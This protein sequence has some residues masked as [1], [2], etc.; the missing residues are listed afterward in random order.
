MP[1]G[2]SKSL[3]RSIF[4]FDLILLLFSEYGHIGRHIPESRVVAAR[5]LSGELT[6]VA[7]GA[8]RRRRRVQQSKLRIVN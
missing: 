3:F 7:A 2:K 4:T 6:A 5:Q 8:N 1:L